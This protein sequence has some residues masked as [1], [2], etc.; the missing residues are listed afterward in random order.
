MVLIF[1]QKTQLD[2]RRR[3]FLAACSVTSLA[4]LLGNPGLVFGQDRGAKAVDE[5]RGMLIADPHA[6]PEGIF[7]PRN[8]DPSAPSIAM[9]KSAGV[10]LCVFSA[11]GD[12]TFRGV[13]GRRLLIPG[14]SWKGRGGCSGRVN[15]CFLWKI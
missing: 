11:V 10:A 3:N 1:R 15:Y 9:L 4:G 13:P 6:H 2:M 8:N 12:S 5:L 7:G 14:S